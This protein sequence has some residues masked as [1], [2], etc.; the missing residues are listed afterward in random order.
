MVATKFSQIPGQEA[1]NTASLNEDYQRHVV[2]IAVGDSI[3]TILGK[4][5]HLHKVH[6]HSL[7]P[8]PSYF[9]IVR[10]PHDVHSHAV[11]KL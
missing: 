4:F 3:A 9:T 5:H 6:I 8:L 11:L 2:R 7:S 1:L 10:K